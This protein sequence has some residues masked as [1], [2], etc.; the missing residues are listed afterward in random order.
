MENCQVLNYRKS[1]GRM[2]KTGTKKEKRKV[3][4]KDT[5]KEED[6][7]MTR[8]W[9]KDNEIEII[10]LLAINHIYVAGCVYL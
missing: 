5:E 2:G 3:E 6:G 8:K 10:T 7:E 4:D 1:R 9:R